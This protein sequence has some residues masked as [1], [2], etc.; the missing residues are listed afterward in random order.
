M[1]SRDRRRD[2][3]GAL[4]NVAVRSAVRDAMARTRTPVAMTGR[5]EQVDDDL[6]VAWVRMDAEAIGADPMWSDNYE[7]PGV[8]P[9]I[10]EG[11]TYEGDT[12][13]ITFDEGVAATVKTG[14][15]NKIVLP[16]GAES[17]RRIVIDGDL[18]VIEF[19]DERDVKVGVLDTDAWSMGELDPV[20]MYGTFD[21][22]G[23]FRFKV[24]DNLV[25]LLD[26][27]GLSIQDAA[28][29]L[30]TAEMKA[31]TLRLVDPVGTDSIEMLTASTATMPTPVYRSQGEVIPTTSMVAPAAPL[32]TADDLAIAHVAAWAINTSFGLATMTPPAGYTELYDQVFTEPPGSLH[33]SVASKDPATSASSTFTDTESAFQFAIGSKVIVKGEGPV[34]PSVR[35]ISSAEVYTTGSVGTLIGAKPSGM[36]VD[37]I[38]LAFVTVAAKGGSVPTGWV[39]PPGFIML[40]TA[41]P[42]MTGSGSGQSTLANGVWAKQITAD[43]VAATDFRTTINLPTGQ[44]IMHGV[45]VCVRDG[46][47]IPGGVQ[48]RTAGHPMRRL[49]MK[50]ELAAASQTL[51]DFQNI[52]PSFDNLEL[53]YDT[54]SDRDTDAIR[55]LRLRFNNDSSGTT[56]STGRYHWNVLNNDASNTSQ[57]ADTKI[58]HG[59]INGGAGGINAKSS[60]SIDIYGYVSSSRPVVFSRSWWTQNLV[61]GSRIGHA[62]WDGAS[63]TS[64]INRIQLAVDGGT[65]QFLAGSRAYLYGY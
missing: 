8:L 3:L 46:Y 48:I 23:G 4:I 38:V 43:D 59:R 53:V 62:Q 54:T 26:A 57:L 41:M 25:V 58:L 39:T 42:L 30:T 20:G 7:M 37:D 33:V 21:P 12:A 2:N 13:R 15:T 63:G 1:T 50:T 52:P 18:G 6:D 27:N 55:T 10:R 64:K 49:L 32:F 5:V 17:G 9:T 14:G 34:S 35:S 24:G 61:L 65:T 36:A 47:L 40:G 60:G 28:T 16:Y 56:G 29:G 31:G 19:Y 22:Q 44:K 51:C 11:D 45:L